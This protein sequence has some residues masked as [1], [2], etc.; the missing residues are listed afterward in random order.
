MKKKDD[1][2][3][4]D[5]AR[6]KTHSIV[7]GLYNRMNTIEDAVRDIFQNE[8]K[9]CEI[10]EDIDILDSRKL[11]DTAK[12]NIVSESNAVAVYKEEKRDVIYIYITYCKDKELMPEEENKYILLKA[13]GIT[14]D[15][16]NLFSSSDVIILKWGD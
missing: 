1:E 6:K 16:R 4:T 2:R 15:V 13:S 3:F 14:K 7:D 8:L 5:I 11:F 9:E 12:K 10:T